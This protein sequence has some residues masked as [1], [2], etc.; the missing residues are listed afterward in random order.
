MMASGL[1]LLL[2][3]EKFGLY[4]VHWKAANFAAYVD[5]FF[6]FSVFRFLKNFSA[7]AVGAPVVPSVVIRLAAFLA[8]SPYFVVT[9]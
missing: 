6:H 2:Y 1:N 5:Y 4:L 8:G 3:P 7:S 9:F